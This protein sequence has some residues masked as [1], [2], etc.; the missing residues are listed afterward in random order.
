MELYLLRS[1]LAVAEA[2][3]FSGAARAIHSTQ[4]AVSRQ[5]ARLEKELGVQLF[6]RYGRHVECTPTGQ[7][8][9]PLVED[10][11]AGTDRVINVAREHTGTATRK[12]RFGAVP[13]VLASLLAP[14]LVSFLAEH[15][16][17]SVDLV[18]M[19][20]ALI[21][22]A[23]VRGDL[24]CAVITPWGSGR[25]VTRH[26][27]TE[28]ILLVVPEGHPLADRPAVSF[29][30]LAGESILL[31]PAAHNFYNTVAA[32]M[33]KAGIEPRAPYRANY[34]ELT[35]A[36]VRKG[37][38]VAPLPKMLIT[39]DGL[40]GLV[41]IPFAQPLYRNLCL[42][43]ARGRPLPAGARAL[44]NYVKAAVAHQTI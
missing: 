15:P 29:E 5:I 14:I 23:V 44:M 16:D 30:M 1:F 39:S 25:V 36:L 10:V 12:V 34:P 18:G 35:K 24:D 8:L 28:E 2:R 4:S 33:R 38:G 43:Y 37:V 3:S 22:D 26:L 27:L 21:E 6:E 17:M 32:A 19:E 42:V 31:P 9:L 13:N 20:D 41:A 11:V 40:E 7:L